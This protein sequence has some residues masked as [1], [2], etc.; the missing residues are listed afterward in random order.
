[1][2]ITEEERFLYIVM[3]VENCDPLPSK[4]VA[5]F[6]ER[7]LSLGGA[8]SKLSANHHLSRLSF[9]MSSAHSTDDDYETDLGD[10]INAMY[11]KQLKKTIKVQREVTR[12]VLLR[13]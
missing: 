8:G 9:I 13:T 12:P 7:R 5:A 2:Q 10:D 1:M 6:A 11:A 3:M 4:R